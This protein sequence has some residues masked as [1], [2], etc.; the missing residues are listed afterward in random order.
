MDEEKGSR[1]ARFVEFLKCTLYVLL[2][3]I[4]CKKSEKNDSDYDEEWRQ[5]E[6]G[7]P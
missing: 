4:G 5:D 2:V 6:A 1:F 3:L 7:R